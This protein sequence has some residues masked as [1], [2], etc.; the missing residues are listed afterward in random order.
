MLQSQKVCST[1]TGH[2]LCSRFPVKF[3][4]LSGIALFFC[5]LLYAQSFDLAINNNGLSFGNSKRFSGLRFNISDRNV[6]EINGI[7]VTLCRASNNSG[8][9]VN[10]IS[11]GLMSPEAGYLNGIQIGGLGVF[12]EHEL[13]GVSFGLLGSGSGGN[14][15]GIAIGGLGVGA[16]ENITGL[17]I[18]LLGTGAG[19]NIKGI[20]IGGL[21]AGAGGDLTGVSFGLLGAGAGGN[22]TG[23]T[24]GGLG[25][26]AGCDMKGFSM[27]LLGAGAGGN[28]TGITIGGLGA[29]CGCT[30]T[31]FTVGG[32]GAGARFIKGVTVA[33]GR[34]NAAE[35]GSM[36][37]FS[38]SLFNEIKGRQSGLVVGIYNMAY[39]LN[40]FQIG[41]VNYVR[42]N[43]RARKI[44]PLVN[45]NFG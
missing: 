3:Y 9:V 22:I 1:Y 19:A 33:L 36:T 28:M 38:A 43:P 26:G 7:N 40:G 18:G 27:G 23:I 12:T 39:E 14:I 30:L 24:I 35:S 25:A 16:G 32:I 4:L 45:W 5:S 21:G 31:G 15:S 41:L 44:L 11:L 37:G 42:D 17:T 10:G 29:G 2:R 6:E 34:V 20:A 8:A 13:K